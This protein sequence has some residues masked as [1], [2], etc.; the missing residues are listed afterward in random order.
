MNAVVPILLK[1]S[2]SK[3]LIVFSDETLETIK[4][5]VAV[6]KKNH[7]TISQSNEIFQIIITKMLDNMDITDI[8]EDIDQTNKADA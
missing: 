7:C 6:L 8:F 3:D 5:I 4:E 2:D 1:R